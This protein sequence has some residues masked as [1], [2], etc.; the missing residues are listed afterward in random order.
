MPN[1]LTTAEGVL[2]LHSLRSL[3]PGTSADA[4]RNLI[5]L[6]VV[7]GTGVIDSPRAG[8]AKAATAGAKPF[9]AS[10]QAVLAA[11]AAAGHQV[12][13]AVYPAGGVE[14]LDYPA[15]QFA[16]P[17]DDPMLA[18]T[19]SSFARILAGVTAQRVLATHGFRNPQG[20]PIA[21][22]TGPGAARVHALPVPTASETADILRMWSAAT[23][24]SHT[25][26]VIDVSGSM[27]EPA[28]NGRTKIEVAAAAAAGAVGYFPDSSAFGLWA[29]SSDQANGL[30]GRV[31]SA[32]PAQLADPASAA[33]RRGRAA[34]RARWRQHRALR[35][36]A[37]RVRAG[38][39]HLRPGQG[40]LG[41]A[42]D[43]RHERLPRGLS[44]TQLLRRS[45]ARSSIQHVPV[46]IITVGIGDQA[47]IATLRQISAVTGGKTYVVHNPAEIRGV[48]LDAMLQRECRPNC[49]TGR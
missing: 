32:A 8:F 47:D 23:E 12:A 39:Q 24:A 37:G 9:A 15:V 36:R 21:G 10:E 6:M 16:R 26:A 22:A 42:A 11:N 2:T 29:F 46:P 49:S 25:L 3:S 48:F 41:R 13:S 43:R 33:D 38:P 30:P 40:Q 19:A 28:D 31:G 44:L 4:T 20:D 18:S 27:A 35:H 1:P 34:A 17:G 7:L 45:C 14:S 5:G